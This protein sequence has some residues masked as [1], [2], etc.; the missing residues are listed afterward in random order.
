MP[1][2][3]KTIDGIEITVDREKLTGHYTVPVWVV[4]WNAI[5]QGLR[6]G[7]KIPGV[8]VEPKQAGVT[9]AENIA[10]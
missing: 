3:I 9:D 6:V 10:R 8:T 1:T 2:E 5:T 4:N 7:V